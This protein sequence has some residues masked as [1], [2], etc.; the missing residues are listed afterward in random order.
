MSQRGGSSQDASDEAQRLRERNRQSQRQLRENESPSQRRSRLHAEALRAKRRRE[1][2]NDEERE[3]RRRR[4]NQL[5]ADRR[6]HETDEEKE[7]RRALNSKREADRRAAETSEQ[8]QQRRA[9]NAAAQ[10]Q[11]RSKLKKFRHALSD[12]DQ[13]NE[14]N[15]AV[16]G[17]G[18]SKQLNLGEQNVV[19]RQCGARMWDNEKLSSSTRRSG[20]LFSLCCNN[21]KVKLPPVK[22][23][24]DV[25]KQLLNGT[26]EH[27]QLF[28]KCI[29]RLNSSLAFVSMQ[30]GEEHLSGKGPPTFRIQGTCKIYHPVI[31]TTKLSTKLFQ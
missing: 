18:G 29:R 30:V 25:I 17:P 3:E 9:R 24:P 19:C 26:H 20:P 11:R 28:S 23:P 10:A 8:S 31:Y 16:C 27:S 7:R 12:I 14:N 2:E 21:G 6:A 1:N 5:Q 15:L 4:H 22:P 13:F